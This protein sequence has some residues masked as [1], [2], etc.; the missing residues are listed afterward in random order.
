M[1]VDIV[2]AEKRLSRLIK[3]AQ[4]G[5]EVIITERGELVARLMPAGR[6]RA[7]P[8]GTGEGRAI[9]DWL[10]RHPLPV[11]A[12]RSAEEI[13]AAIDEARESWGCGAANPGA[14]SSGSGHAHPSPSPPR[15]P[16]RRCASGSMLP[17][18]SR[19]PC[20]DGLR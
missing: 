11:Y 16:R 18:P 8:A 5:E 13:D 14:S 17:P 1:R 19:S 6:S 15:A 12:R 9:L 7:A 2:E 4:Q 3:Y 10:S 20:R